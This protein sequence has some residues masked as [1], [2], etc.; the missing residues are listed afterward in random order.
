MTL[1]YFVVVV[2]SYI[3]KWGMFGY[4]SS[5]NQDIGGWDVSSGTN[6][7]SQLSELLLDDLFQAH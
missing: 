7:V 5:F 4:A 6:F 3:S 1:I 2:I